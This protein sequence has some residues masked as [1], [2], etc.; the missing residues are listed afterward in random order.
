MN[1]PRAYL[2][3][4]TRAAHDRLEAAFGTHDLAS[5]VGYAA[6]LRQHA[7]ALLPLEAAL[8]RADAATLVADWPSRTRSA[9]LLDD[10]AAL[11]EPLPEAL[12]APAIAGPAAVFG[13]LYVLEGSRL[14]ARLLVRRAEASA[15]PVVR[16]ATAYLR[17]GE[18]AGLWPSFLALL[19]R[20]AY[21]RAA[22]EQTLAGAL[23]AFELFE[24]AALEAA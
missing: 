9:A 1:S 10:L 7:T 21:V 16:A 6:F 20:S 8:E 23:A 24:Q 19:D 15:V 18:G 13:V 2:R 12:A 3:A 4:A 22:P 17:H 5:R 11:G 14:G